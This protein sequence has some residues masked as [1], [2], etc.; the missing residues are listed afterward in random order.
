[1]EFQVE[2]VPESWRTHKYELLI[3]IFFRVY[4]YWFCSSTVCEYQSDHYPVADQTVGPR[5]RLKRKAGGNSG[6]DSDSFYMAKTCS[7]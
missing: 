1:M 3:R 6:N 2:H 5:L 4:Y 7:A